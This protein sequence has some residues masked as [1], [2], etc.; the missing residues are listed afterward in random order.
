M[1]GVCMEYG[2]RYAVAGQLVGGGLV[3]CEWEM[4]YYGMEDT[5]QRT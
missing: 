4:L 1:Y 2:A 3:M 5:V